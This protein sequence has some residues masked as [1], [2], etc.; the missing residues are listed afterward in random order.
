ME[1]FDILQPPLN[2]IFPTQFISAHSDNGRVGARAEGGKGWVVRGEGV[3]GSEGS[4]RWE[5]PGGVGMG[6]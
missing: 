3:A 6:R 5:L 2:S 4:G 1:G